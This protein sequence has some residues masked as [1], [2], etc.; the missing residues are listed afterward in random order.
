MDRISWS[1]FLGPPGLPVR[2]QDIDVF[3]MFGGWGGIFTAGRC[4]FDN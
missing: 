3:D 2:S 1:F 4:L